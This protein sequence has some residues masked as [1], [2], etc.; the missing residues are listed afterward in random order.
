MPAQLDSV[1]LTIVCVIFMH[2]KFVIKVIAYMEIHASRS[3]ITQ[4]IYTF[5]IS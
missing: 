4:Y 3:L 1:L 5:K 2:Y